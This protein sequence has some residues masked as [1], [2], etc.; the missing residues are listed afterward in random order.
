METIRGSG[1]RRP[2]VEVEHAPRDHGQAIRRLLAR[3]LLLS[4]LAVIIPLV[5]AGVIAAP[6]RDD[7]AWLL[8]VARAALAG[9]P[10][11]TAVIELNPP[12]IILAS[13]LPVR[14]APLLGLSPGTLYHLLVG[15]ALL[16][17]AGFTASLVRRLGGAFAPGLGVF[18][19]L[20]AVLFALPGVEFGQREHLIA[21]LLAP[22]LALA[23]IRLDGRGAPPGAALATGGF[24]A[25]ALALK[26]HYVLLLLAV[27]AVLIR[28]GVRGR[29]PER[30]AALIASG[31][32]AA[33]LLALFPAYLTDI[34]PIGMRL[35]GG[36]DVTV[37]RLL[38]DARALLLPLALVGA[39]VWASH[40]SRGATLATPALAAVAAGVVIYLIQGKGWAYHRLP[41]E[42]MLA[43]LLVGWL[44]RA[45]D[46][47]GT[48][49]PRL[50]AGLAIG[51]G[52]L[53]GTTVE[54][55]RVVLDRAWH[56]A[57]S[58]ERW[59]AGIV[60]GTGARSLVGFSE[61]LGPFFPVVN[62]TGVRWPLRYPS[63]WALVGQVRPCPRC[64]GSAPDIR[65]QVIDD[66]TAGRPDLIVVDETARVDLL[67]LLLAD[68]AFE[69][70][71]RQYRPIA[72]AH[73]LRVY[74][75][76][77]SLP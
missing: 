33:A 74:R 75:R 52:L 73:G 8:Y 1:A 35:Y 23:T 13:M 17:L 61:W 12:L 59:L 68:P 5:L 6:L 21:A 9:Q 27:E 60:T 77:S 64:A 20:T 37:A 34:V 69:A 48:A 14:F 39:V 44:A 18:V 58:P 66:V 72:G 50:V 65:R 7:I 67:A 57:D 19:T 38:L 11:Y 22:W 4:S 71:W 28:H 62:E 31:L 24:A 2:P 42:I 10:P 45:L 41:A 49:M 56:A 26:P 40:R 3:V 36:L 47:G 32:L 46:S 54:R 16:G 70:A 55:Q 43:L 29:A 76:L 53:A 51:V 63:M 30:A 15:A 25:L